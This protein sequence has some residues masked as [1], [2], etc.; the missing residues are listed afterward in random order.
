[1]TWAV[2]T[3]NHVTLCVKTVKV[4]L[5]FA[6]SAKLPWTKPNYAKHQSLTDLAGDGTCLQSRTALLFITAKH[7][8][9]DLLG[10]LVECV[11]GVLLCP[12]ETWDLRQKLQHH[13]TMTMTYHMSSE[14]L[15]CNAYMHECAQHMCSRS[16]TYTCAW[17]GCVTV[18]LWRRHH[19]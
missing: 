8:V 19:F 13:M 7:S 3:R 16:R 18:H 5:L 17:G 6:E 15:N 10:P 9:Q 14:L 1:M 2:Y 12:N 11:T 4:I